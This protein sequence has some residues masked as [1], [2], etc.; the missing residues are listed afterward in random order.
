MRS[1]LKSWQRLAWWKK[2]QLATGIA[3]VVVAALACALSLVL[4]QGGQSGFVRGVCLSLT[5]LLCVLILGVFART[6]KSIDLRGGQPD[7]MSDRRRA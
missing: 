7:P 5:P 2:S 4:A 1:Q 6:Q 3:V